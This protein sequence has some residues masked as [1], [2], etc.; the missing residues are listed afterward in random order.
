MNPPRL[1]WHQPSIP[2]AASPASSLTP[3]ASIDD[4]RLPPM[5]VASVASRQ[6]RQ[7]RGTSPAAHAND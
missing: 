1:P 6:R 4:D 5:S 3:P 2:T 7:Q